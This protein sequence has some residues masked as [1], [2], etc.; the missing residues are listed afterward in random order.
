M[1]TNIK[2]KKPHELIIP[3]LNTAVKDIKLLKNAVLGSITRVDNTE[4]IENV[5]SNAMQ[6]ITDKA[7]NKMQQRPQVK[8]LLPVCPDQSSFQTHAQDNN[9]SP[10]QLQN[11]NVPPLIQ[12]KLNE[13][14]NNEFNCIVSK[15]STDFGQTNLVEMDLPTEGPPT[16]TKPYSIPLKYKSVT[17]DEI[18]LLEDAKCTLNHSVTEHLPFIS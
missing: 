1:L 17:D 7:C 9:K 8:P 14:L 4:C 2:N 13:M 12:I 15:S 5:S 11:V 18:R 6:F 10:I 16:A 3:I